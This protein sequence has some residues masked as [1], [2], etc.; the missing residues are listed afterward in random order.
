VKEKQTYELMP[1][2]A[3]KGLKAR[4]C[5]W[6]GSSA[7]VSASLEVLESSS[8]SCLFLFLLSREVVEA[9]AR[10]RVRSG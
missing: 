2:A 8:S 6:E 7:A 4:G 9:G 5:P 1:M 3:S 10:W